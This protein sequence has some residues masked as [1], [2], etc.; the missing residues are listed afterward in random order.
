MTIER[1]LGGSLNREW[2]PEG[3][4]VTFTVGLDR[5]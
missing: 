4:C 5:L 2:L 3:L 1:Q